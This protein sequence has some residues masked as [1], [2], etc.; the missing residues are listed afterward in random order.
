MLNLTG[1]NSYTGPTTVDGGLLK[2]NGAI[3][4]DVVIAS[5]GSLGGSGRVGGSISIG[6]GG[7]ISPGNSPGILTVAGDLTF[8]AGSTYVAQVQPG[9]SP[10]HD[11]IK[12]T[13]AGHVA[14]IVDGAAVQVQPA[15]VA[16]DYGRINSYAILTADGGV[17]GSFDSHLSITGDLP[18]KPYLVY[19]AHEVDLVL[20]RTDITFASLASTSNQA[21]VA[22]AVEAGGFGT[23]LFDQLV[24][25]DAPES[26]AAYDALSGELYASVP[27]AMIEQSRYVRQSLLG[28]LGQPEGG[29]AWG[30]YLGGWARGGATADTGAVRSDLQ[31][32]ILGVDHAAGPDWRVGAAGAYTVSQVHV[33]SRDSH[34][35]VET[36]ELSAYAGGD[37]GPVAAR[38]EASYGW[39][40]VHASR[41]V[42][43]TGFA[44]ATRASY[45]AHS[46]E[47]V[48]EI[49]RALR[50]GAA[51]V[52]PYADL[53]YQRLSTDA[54]QEAGGDAA[55][56]VAG[57]SR[58]ITFAA[59][60]VRISDPVALSRSLTLTPHVSAAWR[61]AWGDV[62][63]RA[64]EAF[65]SSG[66]AFS[67]AGARLGRSEAV[68]DAGV[69]LSGRRGAKLT[70]T[71][72]GAFSNRWQDHAVK[73]GAAWTF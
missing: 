38:V 24:T 11:Q 43:F 28:R 10:D 71:Y 23:A 46:A 70:L 17:S 14:T 42:D 2:V 54:F 36:V 64:F 6:A 12:V 49:G 4:S 60:G 26:R 45:D 41:T 31:G 67:V 29:G 59:G 68:V 55:L 16:G 47:I 52:E 5:G 1:D 39:H 30:K 53:G 20:L 34:A 40:D 63:G 15:G 69:D 18:L 19:S 65:Q 32:F 35:R 22:N 21:A 3:V 9:A 27:T 37:L 73:L 8:G 7:A 56:A 66:Q 57:R 61:G 25:L 58:D 51:T 48:G 72:S 13:G 62:D 44:D 33:A 50:L